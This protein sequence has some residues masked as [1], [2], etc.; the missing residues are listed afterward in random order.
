M[1]QWGFEAHLRRMTRLYQKRRDFMVQ[2][3]RSFQK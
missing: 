3:L 1:Q 2:Q